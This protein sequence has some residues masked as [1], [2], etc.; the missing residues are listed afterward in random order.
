MSRE[1]SSRKAKLLRQVQQQRLDLS[2]EKKQWLERTAGYDS[3]W[4]TLISLRRYLAVGSSLM[5][6]WSIRNPRKITRWVR[7]G[8]GI[9]S[10]W[11]MVRNYLPRR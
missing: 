4:L 6:V 7:G 2:A 5:A 8:L 3:G 11:R 9:W 1:L 10:S